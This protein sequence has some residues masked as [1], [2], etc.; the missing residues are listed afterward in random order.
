M[1]G[2]WELFGSPAAAVEGQTPTQAAQPP[3]ADGPW[4]LFGQIGPQPPRE[5]PGV[6]GYAADIGEQAVRGFNKGLATVVTAPYRAVDWAAEKITGGQG[7]PDV[8]TMPLWKQYLDQPDAR[9]TPGR[10]AA[11]AGEVI[12]SSAVPVGAVMSQA[13]RLAAMVPTTTMGALG[14]T[15]GQNI[16][17][18]PGAAL[19]LDVAS[20]VSGGVAEQGAKE[21]GYGPAAQT[22]AGMIGSVIPGVPLAY[23]AASNAPIGTPTGRNI[24]QQRADATAR[25]VASFEAQDVRPFG[26]AF[27]QGPVASVGKQLTETPIIGAP[28][29]NNLDETYHDAAAAVGRLAD[30]VSPTATPETAGG[31]LQSGLTR[32]RNAGLKD[33][34]QSVVEGAGLPS[35]VQGPV[36]DV[37]SQGAARDAQQ[38]AP[39]RQAIGA[40]SAQ[41][42]R[43]VTVP[44]ARTR[45][46]TLTHRTEASDLTDDQL[47]ALVRM[48]ATE[49]S[50]ATRAEALYER[51]WRMVPDILRTNG[52]ANANLVSPVNTR[53]A[54]NQADNQVANQIAGQGVIGGEVAARLRNANSNITLEDLRAIRT[55][56]GRAMANW[57][58]TA[59]NTLD[60]TQL[61]SL[62][63]ATS[64][65]IE[66]AL[67]TLANRAALRTL[68]NTTGTAVPVETARQAAG[69]LRAFR[70]ADRYFRGTQ[71]SLDRFS[72]VLNAQSPEAAARRVVQAAQAGDKGNAQ[73][74]RTAMAGLR[75]DERAEVGS[76]V[77]RSMGTPNASAR[78][79]VQESGFSPSSFVT[80]YQAMNQE[81]RALLFTP[82]HQRALDQ[83]FNVANRLANVEAMANTSRT[84]TNTMNMGG[85]VAGA[86]AIM[87]GDV[88]TPLAI[89]TSGIAT[90][91]LMSSPAYTRW[92]A[93]YVNL[94]AAVRSGSDRSVAPLMRHV[95][96]LERQAQANPTIMPAFYEVSQEVKS[97]TPAQPKNTDK[98]A[99]AVASKLAMLDDTAKSGLL[100]RVQARLQSEGSA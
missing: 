28:L 5:S 99:E 12:G 79:I 66:I 65:D 95:A 85:A 82:E 40:D 76:M 23:R 42:T 2:P 74:V 10:Y 58:P 71:E 43:G 92:M 26:P 59:Q 98:R 63:G 24:A 54:L 77:I 87:T 35:T 69:A 86:G 49:T 11:K 56:I 6:L 30:N 80:R 9:T 47:Q 48:P 75:P 81:A 93:T 31:A 96:G 39:I 16:T 51:A 62:Y 37:M 27:N 4:S 50:A 3:V 84:G 90:S 70:T 97:L 36:R 44:T 94:R 32:F 52:T 20:G 78:G 1:S 25:D 100:Q 7:L 15:I 17:A 14:Q 73:L 91:L 72:S 88:V 64:R 68:P 8:E 33:L 53:M 60:K 41:T 19:A 38:A 57:S 45:N 13:P 61:R 34:E 18:G 83:L 29:R 89:G 67:E 22:A 21:A 55:E 46:Q